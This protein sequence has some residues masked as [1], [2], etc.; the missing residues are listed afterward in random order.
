[1][2]INS[3]INFPV[4][5]LSTPI[6]FIELLNSFKFLGLNPWKTTLPPTTLSV[7]DFNKLSICVII[8]SWLLTLLAASF[9][10]ESIRLKD[11]SIFLTMSFASKAAD[12][13]CPATLISA[14]NISWGFLARS[15]KGVAI[16][17]SINLSIL[18]LL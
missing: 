9:D 18:E 13:S 4:S 5:F 6:L 12:P 7:P 16:Y 2:F 15:L 17:L 10:F 3:E 1:M 11:W 8:L 14:S